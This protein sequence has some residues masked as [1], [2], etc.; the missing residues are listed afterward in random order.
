MMIACAPAPGRTRPPAGATQC[1]SGA[2]RRRCPTR[3]CAP[4]TTACWPG[5]GWACPCWRYRRPSRA[6]PAWSESCRCRS[7]GPDAP[8][9]V[10]AIGAV[11]PARQEFP[12]VSAASVVLQRSAG[13]VQDRQGVDG[14]NR[15]GPKP[16]GRRRSGPRR[17]HGLQPRLQPEDEGEGHAEDDPDC[18]PGLG[19]VAQL[20]WFDLPESSHGGERP[21]LPCLVHQVTIDDSLARKLL[22]HE[23]CD[24]AVIGHCKYGE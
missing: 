21:F 7:P 11:T 12:R 6:R 2:C 24:A 13:Q 8:W 23:A 15:S 22:R 16:S 10:W 17:D 20:S 19:R 4:P 9:A 3:G 18:T 14:H 1:A 5:S